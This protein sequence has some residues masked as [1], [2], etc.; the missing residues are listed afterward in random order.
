[1]I[2]K[3]KKQEISLN[4]EDG[5][6]QNHI[7]KIDKN[8]LI[9]S[10]GITLSTWIVLIAGIFSLQLDVIGQIPCIIL[11]VTTS[12]AFLFLLLHDNEHTSFFYGYSKKT[13]LF[14]V[15]YIS[16]LIFTFLSSFLPWWV[17]GALPLAAMLI[18]SGTEIIG[19]LA[20]L[21][22][23]LLSV[24][25]HGL[26][27]EMLM[28]YLVVAVVAFACFGKKREHELPLQFLFHFLFSFLALVSARALVEKQ[29]RLSIILFSLLACFLSTG[30]LYMFWFLVVERIL[31][32]EKE[33]YQELNDPEN[34]LLVELKTTNP[35]SY[36]HAVHTAYFC[37]KLALV[38]GADAR[39]AKAG[40]YYHKIGKMR[41]EE[42]LKNTLMIA[43]E[44]DFPPKLRQILL[45]YGS[46]NTLIQSKEA[47]LILFSDAMVS[48]VSYLFEQDKAATPDYAKIAELVISR[49]LE[50]RILDHCELTLN[51]IRQIKKYF[52]KDTV[53]YD[54]L[55]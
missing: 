32:S 53:Y 18:I 37:E 30:L 1:M 14:L 50:S 47:A 13:N 48:T 45:E 55:R 20:F 8:F 38:I 21:L 34:E 39:L 17:F 6:K 16:G 2:M 41:S 11:L 52:A 49:N 44:Y 29:I 19:F 7:N 10:Y 31:Q 27:A 33:Q 51:D 54:F 9:L 40:G 4:T 46:K 12:L 26:S 23:S 5:T 36:Y 42:N 35:Q 25:L 28:G 24:I 43:N 22:L 15:I 3:K